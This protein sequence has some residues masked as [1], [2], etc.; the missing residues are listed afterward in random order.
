MLTNRSHFLSIPIQPHIV[1]DLL[2]GGDALIAAI[3]NP[4]TYESSLSFQTVHGLFGT[5]A[6]HIGNLMA[7]VIKELMHRQAKAGT[8]EWI[9]VRPAKRSA[10]APVETVTAT[11][12]QG[13]VGDHYHGQSGNRQVTLIQAEHLDGVG[14]MLGKTVDPGLTRR[15]IVVR[16]I[17]LLSFKEQ[18]FAVGS[19]ILEMTGLCHPCSR[20]EEN[21]GTGGYNAMRGHGGITAR[22]LEG[23]EIRLGDVV[24]LLSPD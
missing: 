8:V 4:Q 7:E 5:F 3:A 11:T 16:G 24:S 15:N 12:D 14:N 17:N 13:L 10:L 20:M 18:R 23:G 19:T 22:V 2:H 6:W 1:K 9:G 21:L